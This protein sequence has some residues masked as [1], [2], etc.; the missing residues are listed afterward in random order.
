MECISVS[1]N[2][3]S[4]APATEPAH[5]VVQH[6]GLVTGSGRGH[7]ATHGQWPVPPVD[8]SRIANSNAPLTTPVA[9]HNLPIDTLSNEIPASDTSAPAT[10]G[11]TKNDT[12]GRAWMR[13]RNGLVSV[14]R[15]FISSSSNPA[16]IAA[17]PRASAAWATTAAVVGVTSSTR[18][19]VKIPQPA[20]AATA[21]L[22]VT[23]APIAR[24]APATMQSVRTRITALGTPSAIPM[25]SARGRAPHIPASRPHPTLAVPVIHITHMPGHHVRPCDGGA[26]RAKLLSIVTRLSCKK[27]SWPQR[28]A[29]Y[30]TCRQEVQH[31]C[32]N[33]CQGETPKAHTYCN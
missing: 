12:A 20:H 5:A 7:P 30:A 24:F 26:I 31:Q 2:G 13:S 32:S 23:S 17:N 19:R 3:Q 21:T 28:Q 29:V 22:F 10:T 27:P 14:R 9:M 6:H 8:V 11:H 15:P 1:S 33:H 25:L 4:N 18:T 16:T